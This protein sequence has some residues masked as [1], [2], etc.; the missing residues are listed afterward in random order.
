MNL[1]IAQSTPTGAA[2]ASIVSTAYDLAEVIE[3]ELLRRSFNQVYGLKLADGR[4]VVAR[5]SAHRPR[6]E[7]NIDYEAALADHL[8]DHGI[9][10]A[11]CLRPIGGNTAI[12]VALPEGDRPL[13]LFEHLEGEFTGDAHEDIQ[14]FGSGL[15][16]LHTAA[17]NFQGTPSR[18]VLDL[19]Y[20]LMRPT[21]R[22]MTAPTMT[23]ELRAQFNTIATRLHARI[24]AM[25]GLSRVVCH[26]DAHGQNNFIT[27]DA[28]GKRVASF[29]DFDEAGP[30]YL[31]YELAVYP[32]G[33]HPR[34]PEKDMDAK[35]LARWHAFSAA[36]GAVRPISDADLAAVPAFMAVRQFWLLGEYAGRIPV[37]GS[38]A[39]PTSYL[40]KQ[41]A[42]LT[43]WETMTLST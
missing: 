17:E 39:M 9:P 32:W 23:D 2:I 31:S 7:P 12:P 1:A 33:M 21:E 6:G 4:K 26:G 37:W 14:A 13:M 30:G 25:Q 16:A 35:A 27:Q 43:N 36:Y 18:Y 19:D 29:F 11:A 22:L 10:V 15:A 38:Q 8:R 34:N 41:A 40:R 20:L 3:C 5:L 28:T 24:S 42:M